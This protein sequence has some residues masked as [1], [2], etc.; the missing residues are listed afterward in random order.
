[1]HSLSIRIER[2]MRRLIVASVI[3]LGACAS[4][5]RSGGAPSGVQTVRVVD[6]GGQVT[7]LSTTV[8]QRSGIANV[9]HSVD[10]VW[11]A[12]PRVYEAVGIPI[13]QVNAGT[14]TIGNPGLT[15]RRQLGGVPIPRY[16]DCG[17]TQDR[18]SAETYELQ[19]SVLSQVKGNAA[20][21]TVTTTVHATARPLNFATGAVRCSST[22]ALETR[23][24]RA[25]AEQM[26]E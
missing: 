8:V 16:F 10:D 18:P 15:A 5:G 1:M 26:Q 22:G 9:P 19:I 14:R 17:R 20:D 6:G 23:I 7:A 12:L 2:S 21:A 25:L 3:A 4:S 11:R 24:S 13:S